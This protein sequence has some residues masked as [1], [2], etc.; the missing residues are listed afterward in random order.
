MISIEGKLQNEAKKLES[1]QNLY[2]KHTVLFDDFGIVYKV[3]KR[4]EL[5]QLGQTLFNHL[6]EAKSKLNSAILKKLDDKVGDEDSII[7][8]QWY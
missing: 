3:K 4:R 8:K 6:V 2:Y 7:L 5:V 1:Q